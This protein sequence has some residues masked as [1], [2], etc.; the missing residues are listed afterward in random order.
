[1]RIPRGFKGVPVL[2]PNDPLQ[3]L[4]R[5]A[6]LHFGVDGGKLSVEG[7]NRP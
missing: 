7:K 6:L 3:P 1:M 2:L 4:A 5:I